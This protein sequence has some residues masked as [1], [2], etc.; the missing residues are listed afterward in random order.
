MIMA[1]KV[2]FLL[3][4]IRFT[5]RMTDLMSHL[6]TGP[7]YKPDLRNLV[8]ASPTKFGRVHFELEKHR[9]EGPVWSP[10]R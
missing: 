1:N 2:P 9:M 5:L 4:L 10:D 6:H 3:F 7:Q 8:A